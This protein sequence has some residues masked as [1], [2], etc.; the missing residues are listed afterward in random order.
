MDDRTRTV[1]VAAGCTRVRLGVP[2]RW[3]WLSD[4]FEPLV[5]KHV[6]DRNRDHL[7]VFPR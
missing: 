7:G 1:S 2:R 5:D 4:V 3:I 6:S